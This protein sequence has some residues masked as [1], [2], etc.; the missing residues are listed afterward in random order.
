MGRMGEKITSS[1]WSA[2]SY[3]PPER[4]GYN[5]PDQIT[6][7]NFLYVRRDGLFKI[8]TMHGHNQRNRVAQS[9]FLKWGY[10]S[11]KYVWMIDT[12]A[13]GGS[14]M[15]VGDWQNQLHYYD[16]ILLINK[17]RAGRW[18]AM[19]FHPWLKAEW[20]PS[21]NRHEIRF[22]RNDTV[23]PRPNSHEVHYQ[24]IR[25]G[26][27]DYFDSLRKKRY[28]RLERQHWIAQGVIKPT[29]PKRKISEA[30][31]E[32]RRQEFTQSLI[33]N[34]NIHTPARTTSL[35]KEVDNGIDGMDSHDANGEEVLAPR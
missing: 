20:N 33:S 35:R 4:I 26:D 18:S 14:Y 32:A 27:F 34:M 25:P 21:F 10:V 13:S 24:L 22:A 29:T 3:G 19:S 12:S 2:T 1:Y 5:G 7:S 28:R 16:E 30:E 9:S 11:G 8:N 23:T 31:L 15:H 17:Y 6:L